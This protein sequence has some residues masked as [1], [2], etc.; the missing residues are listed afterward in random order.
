[1]TADYRSTYGTSSFEMSNII[2]NALLCLE[3]EMT[4]ATTDQAQAI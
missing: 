2:I 4:Q 1:M 3:S